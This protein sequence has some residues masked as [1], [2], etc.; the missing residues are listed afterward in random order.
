M[1]WVI[2]LQG[3]SGSGKSTLGRKLADE[4]ILKG[5]QAV[6]VSADHLFEVGEEYRFNPARLG[7]AHARCFRAFVA[8]LTS[9]VDLV[10]V[11]NTNTKVEY[12]SPYFMTLSAYN[13]SDKYDFKVIQVPCT[14]EV[15]ASRN[16]HS[17]G[18]KVVSRMAREISQC[19]FPP[20]WKIERFSV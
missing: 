1:K 6:I 20:G 13:C 11:D 10:I 12:I 17:V 16:L 19:Q 2:V 3:V 15:A 4:T 18:K 8:A 9:G 5:L 7:E 14:V